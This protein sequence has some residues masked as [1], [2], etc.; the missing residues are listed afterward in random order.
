[1]LREIIRVKQQP[2]EGHKRWFTD[3]YWDLFVWLD[4]DEIIRFQ[5]CYGKP[6][7]EKAVTWTGLGNLKH[8]RIDDGEPQAGIGMTPLMVQDDNFDSDA[9]SSRFLAESTEID[10]TV[11]GFVY[12]R[13]HS[14]TKKNP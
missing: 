14:P 13:I 10:Q 4:Q 9:V 8:T 2:G 5:L 6:A 1:M 11:A 3:R 7:D 12:E